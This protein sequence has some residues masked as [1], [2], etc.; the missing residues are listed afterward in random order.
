MRQ[1]D[2]RA[3]SDVMM[4][5]CSRLDSM[6]STCATSCSSRM[7][8]RSSDSL[9]ALQLL[10]TLKPKVHLLEPPGNGKLPQFHDEMLLDS[11]Q[12][13]QNGKIK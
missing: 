4:T 1:I 13:V 5:S 6:F 8:R 3:I 11:A 10:V 2:V 7:R 12:N 9:A